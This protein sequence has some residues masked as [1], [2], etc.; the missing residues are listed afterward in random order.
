MLKFGLKYILVVAVIQVTKQQSLPAL[1][2]TD[3]EIKSFVSE[4][5]N[6]DVNAAT[7]R[8]LKLNFQGHTNIRST[9][10]AAPQPLFQFVNTSIF[11]KPT[12]KAYIDLMDNYIPDVG[13][14]EQTTQEENNEMTTF[15][16]AIMKTEIGSKLFNLLKTKGHPYAKDKKTF[17]KWIMQ[18]W[19]GLYSRAKGVPD[20]SGF[21]H[22]F[23]GE[24][25]NGEVSGLHNWIRLYFLETNSGKENFDYMGFLVKRFDLM[26]SIKY[27]WR[28]YMKSGGSFFVG[29]SPEF[30]FSVYTLCLLAKRGH[31]G[32]AIEV[33][34][35]PA[36]II[37]HELYQ[38][39]KVFIGSL[40]PKVE[41]S[42]EQCKKLN[43]R[44]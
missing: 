19:F 11:R 32:C 27:K 29:T 14:P 8:D 30:D 10:D 44:N 40:Y 21:E 17:K 18:L 5:W 2:I 37:V 43:S 31:K 20:T 42:T 25:K 16:E 12:Y 34:G 24:I 6:S 4:I 1:S 33:N 13:T 35:C 28:H 38:N 22:V 15:Y 36:S 23:I 7:K 9:S 39:N 26:A 3:N 41:M